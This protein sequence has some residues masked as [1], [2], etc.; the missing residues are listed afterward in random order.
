MTIS[1]ASFGGLIPR[2]DETAL[3]D[4]AAT[5]ALCCRLKTTKLN[6]I[7]SA[8]DIT[9][10]PMHVEGGLTDVGDARTLCLW[11][12]GRAFRDFLAWRGVVH[13]APSNIFADKRYRI[14]VTGETGEGTPGKPDQPCAYICSPDGRFFDRHLL[15]KGTPPPPD[16]QRQATGPAPGYGLDE[17]NIRYTVFFQSFVDEYGYESGASMPSQEAE[18]NDG[19]KVTW[20]GCP[21]PGGIVTRRLYKAVAGTGIATIKFVCEQPVSATETAFFDKTVM[22]KDE[23][24][25]EEMPLITPIPEDLDWMTAMPGNF[26]AGFLK[27]EPR[28]ICFS[29]VG[30]ATSWPDAF[31]YDIRDEAV[32]IAVSGSTAFILTRGYPWAISG[33][34]PD[35]M[36][37]AQITSEQ[38]CVS[39]RSICAF[40]GRVFYASQDGVCVLA[41]DSLTSTVLTR[42][43]FDKV[44]WEALNPPSCIMTAYDNALFLW[45]EQTDGTPLAY[46]IDFDT[47]G[48][49]VITR[50]SDFAQAVCVDCEDDALYFVRRKPD[51]GA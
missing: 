3:P 20:L 6:P 41:E 19:D 28:S 14:F 2:I 26:Y 35:G 50:H 11:Q 17:A 1:F 27:S 8:K 18:Y 12:R 15:T 21:I 7:R 49:P 16:V 10:R 32:G 36:T 45:F 48:N 47:G 34:A 31:R 38:A 39:A 23:D 5:R 40:E 42:N 33:S 46:I 43:Y 37:A 9:G 4:T 29:D 25:G 30:L 22:V 24:T 51:G 13:V 44:A